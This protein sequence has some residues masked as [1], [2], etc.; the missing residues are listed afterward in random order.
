LFE[1]AVFA[2]INLGDVA[3]GGAMEQIH[4]SLAGV[5]LIR[6]K[7]LTATETVPAAARLAAGRRR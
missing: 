6:L 5:N 7:I 2:A 3:T 4:H 1:E